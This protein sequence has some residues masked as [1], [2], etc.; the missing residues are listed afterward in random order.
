MLRQAFE[1]DAIG[2]RHGVIAGLGFAEH[3][4]LLGLGCVG[5]HLER[6]AHFRQAFQ[7]N[8]FDGLRRVRGADGRALV[9][10]HRTDLAEHGTAD[11]EVA[12]VERAV[13]DE[14]CGDGSAG[15]TSIS[16]V[17][18]PPAEVTVRSWLPTGVVGLT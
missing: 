8:D 3:H 2:L 6:I 5:H 4:D 9:I 10:E 1:C 18:V 7:S 15:F 16:R 12:D 13:A 17:A 11:E 14:D